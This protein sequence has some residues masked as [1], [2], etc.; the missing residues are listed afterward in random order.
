MDY[1][2]KYKKYK[3]KYLTLI[4]KINMQ[5]G[6]LPLYKTQSGIPEDLAN[7][8]EPDIIYIEGLTP[9]VKKIFQDNYQPNN[10]ELFILEKIKEIG[11]DG[12]NYVEINGTTQGI[13]IYDIRIYKVDIYI[14]HYYCF[15]YLQCNTKSGTKRI[16]ITFSK[17]FNKN[18]PAI[19]Y[20]SNENF[21]NDL[22]KQLSYIK[23]SG[24][25]SI[26]KQIC[27]EKII[28]TQLNKF[29]CKT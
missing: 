4:K 13:N 2:E 11:K 25:I 15:V 18:Q 14:R 22:Q 24:I 29:I 5:G 23:D 10:A 17:K 7:T 3:N 19:G 9:D 1:F 27:E 8:N 21:A 26:K 16:I 6:A 12:K 20:N 28:T